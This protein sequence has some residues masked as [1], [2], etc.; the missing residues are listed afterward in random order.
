M[1]DAIYGKA[2]DIGSN[3]Q[4]EYEPFVEIVFPAFTKASALLS[5]HAGKKWRPYFGSLFQDLLSELIL[6][7]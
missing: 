6:N 2:S 7:R 4:K 5:G 1:R 3:H